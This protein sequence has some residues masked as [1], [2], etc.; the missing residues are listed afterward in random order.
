MAEKSGCVKAGEKKLMPVA[1]RDHR[2]HC[3]QAWVGV[4]QGP[5]AGSVAPFLAGCHHTCAD[6]SRGVEEYLFVSRRWF[7]YLLLVCPS[8]AAPSRGCASRGLRALRSGSRAP[9][10]ACLLSH[11]GRRR[12]YRCGTGSTAPQ[13]RPLRSLI[14]GGGHWASNRG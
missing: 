9:F 10:F 5:P 11:R 4:P 7:G 8:I 6:L 1:A 12:C 2:L 13:K 14:A 3:P